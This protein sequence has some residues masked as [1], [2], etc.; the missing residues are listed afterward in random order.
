MAGTLAA[1]S[2]GEYHGHAMR[3][4]VLL[5]VASGAEALQAGRAVLPTRR[6]APVRMEQAPVVSPLTSDCQW[7]AKP[8]FYQPPPPPPPPRFS[9]RWWRSEPNPIA[10]LLE[11]AQRD[12]E[13]IALAGKAALLPLVLAAFAGLAWL[14]D[15]NPTSVRVSLVK[16]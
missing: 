3:V 15:V 7:W 1:D 2:L 16:A 9:P 14:L 8:N 4:A 11:F 5:L 10:S 13:I 6:A 12:N